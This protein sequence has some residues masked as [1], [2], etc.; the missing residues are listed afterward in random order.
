MQTFKHTLG[1]IALAALALTGTAQAQTVTNGDFDTSLAGWN[2]G[3]GFTA[4]DWLAGT[5]LFN[6]GTDRLAQVISGLIAGTEYVYSFT[7]ASTSASPAGGIRLNFNGVAYNPAIQTFA[8][9][10]GNTVTVTDSFFAT[11]SGNLVMAFRGVNGSI[12]TL[13]NVSI[14]AVPE[15]ETYAMLLAGL[16]AIGF[17]SRRRQARTA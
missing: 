4:A 2:T 9:T 6:A 17:M 1:A 3:A 10:A 11:G 8:G 7:Y 16:G 12:T 5:A 14:T 15:P 13:D